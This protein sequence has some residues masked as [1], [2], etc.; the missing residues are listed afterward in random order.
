MKNLYGEDLENM[1][2]S[3]TGKI[4]IITK[5]TNVSLIIIATTKILTSLLNDEVTDEKAMH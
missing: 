3:V 2:V 4:S 5:A 1:R